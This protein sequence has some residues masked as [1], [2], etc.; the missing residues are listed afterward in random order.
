MLFRQL[1]QFTKS[2]G[3]RYLRESDTP[4]LRRFR[5]SWKD[6]DLAGLKKLD[7]LRAFFR[8]SRENG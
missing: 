2:E 3:I 8:F 7:R 5:A 6:G 1:E 4:T